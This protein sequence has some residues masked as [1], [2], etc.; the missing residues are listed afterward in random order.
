MNTWVVK[1]GGSVAGEA[2]DLLRE[3]AH[4]VGREGDRV[5]VVHG[6]GPEITELLERLGHASSFVDGQR[7]TDAITLDAAE[8]VLAGRVGK[9]IVRRLQR[10]GVLAVGLSGEDGG[11][12][13][14]EPYDAT[15]RLGRVGRVT[16][17]RRELV[18]LLWQAGYVPVLA[19]LALGEDGE[20]LNVNADFV[21]GALAGALGADV[22]V[23]ATDVP[24]V[25]ESRH[26][27]HAIPELSAAEVREMIGS[28][29]IAGGMIPKVE[30]AL[31]AVDAG[32]G[33]AHIVDGRGPA[34]LAA[35][36]RGEPVGTR[37]VR[38]AS[39]AILTQGSGESW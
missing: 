21:A 2:G 39:P 6:G 1:Y 26:A 8:M 13:R 17:V 36:R 27:Q 10:A 11:L 9:R 23:L 4:M 30:A 5:A 28:G 14:A 29:A 3:V 16:A 25:K 12:V 31:A 32:A 24:G 20:L 35:L 38:G 37:I 18:D 7:V 34:V 15:G 33:E 22:F 19:P